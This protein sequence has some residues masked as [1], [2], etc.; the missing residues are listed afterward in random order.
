MPAAGRGGLDEELALDVPGLAQLEGRDVAGDIVG[1]GPGGGE[2][3]L[4]VA[5]AEADIAA[6]FVAGG[7]A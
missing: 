7:K 2:E 4:P 1:V 6:V 5:S 3:I